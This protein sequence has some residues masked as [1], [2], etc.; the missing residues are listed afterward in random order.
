MSITR[1]FSTVIGEDLEIQVKYHISDP[2]PQTHDDPGCDAELT[3]EA[4][5]FGVCWESP[6]DFPQL[7]LDA[8]EEAAR[9][10]HLKLQKARYD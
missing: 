9:N 1:T 3:I 10:H 6:D 7:N 2:V 8:L 5:K 4:V